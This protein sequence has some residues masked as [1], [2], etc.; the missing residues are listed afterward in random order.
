MVSSKYI[1]FQ[2][3]VKTGQTVAEFIER[4]YVSEY[5]KNKYQ[6]GNTID[7]SQEQAVVNKKSQLPKREFAISV[8]DNFL[9]SYPKSPFTKNEFGS[10]TLSYHKRLKDDNTFWWGA[11]YNV[12]VIEYFHFYEAFFSFVPSM[13]ISYLNRPNTTLYSGVS[14][15]LG[16]HAHPYWGKTPFLFYQVTAIGF[17]VGKKSFIG[18]EL[19]FGV[20]GLGCVC[21]GYRF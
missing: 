20:K 21:Y 3:K 14:L 18:G 6:N 7:T 9:I 19:G 17:S 4:S 15:G 8:G 16:V 13:R 10:Y 12:I 2:E 11:Y 5:H 1:K